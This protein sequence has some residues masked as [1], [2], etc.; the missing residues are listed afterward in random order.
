[1]VHKEAGRAGELVLLGRQH[2]HGEFFSGQ[3]CS[4]QLKAFRGLRLV[5]VNYS[6][7]LVGASRLELLDRIG[8]NLV[9]R[10]AWSVIIRCLA[11]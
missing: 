8:R 5:L 1:M 4:G 10:L 6:G 11:A 3:V 7:R 9:V 2:A